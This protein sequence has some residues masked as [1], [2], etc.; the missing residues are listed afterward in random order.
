MEAKGNH[1]G[2]RFRPTDEWNPMA[3]IDYCEEARTHPGSPD[4]LLALDIQLAEW[5]LLFDYCATPYGARS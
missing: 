4:E 3:F 1:Q 5:Q 2:A